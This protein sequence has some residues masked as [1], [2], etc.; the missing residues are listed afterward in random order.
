[1]S[2]EEQQLQRYLQ[3]AFFDGDDSDGDKNELK[4][5]LRKAE[6]E[7]QMLMQNC[8]NQDKKIQDQDKEI[9]EKIQEI[10]EIKQR[11]LLQWALKGCFGGG[12]VGAVGGGLYTAKEGAVVGALQ[13]GVAGGV[14]GFFAGGFLGV[15]CL[16]DKTKAAANKNEG[17]GTKTD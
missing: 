5:K 10:D 15:L 12:T 1:M 13:G 3:D 2:Q 4:A 11:K 9:Q 16:A 17:C 7:I 6:M 14:F 8:E